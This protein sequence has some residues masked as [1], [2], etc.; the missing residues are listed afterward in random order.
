M[1]FR[2]ELEKVWDDTLSTKDMEIYISYWMNFPI[3]YLY[4]N[5]K[6]Y[7]YSTCLNVIKGTLAPGTSLVS[8]QISQTYL[9]QENDK[10]TFV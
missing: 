6:L 5:N 9:H 10:C 1:L 8:T 4:N 3:I 7:S 2:E